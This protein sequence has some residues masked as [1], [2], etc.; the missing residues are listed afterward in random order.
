MIE[1]E[2]FPDFFAAIY[3]FAPFPWQIRLLQQVADSGR[4]PKL[5]DLPTGSG[6][7]ACIDIAVFHLAWRLSH[8]QAS[9]AARR[10]A[11]VVDRRIVVDQAADRARGLATALKT[12]PDPILARV[13]GCLRQGNAHNDPLRVITLRGGTLRERAV[14]RSLVEPTIILSTVD[15]LG[16]RMLFRGYGVSKRAAPMHAGMLA[17]DTLVLLDEAHIALPLLQTL[18]GIQRE[19]QRMQ[20][21]QN[22]PS[23]TGPQGFALAELTA[24]PGRWP[25]FS[26][27][28]DDHAHPLLAQRLN[29]SKP[30]TLH[31][32]EDRKA[33]VKALVEAVEETLKAPPT[34]NETPR[35]A[36]VVNRV[37]SAREIFE[38][39]AKKL[40]KSATVIL[41]TGRSRP[42]DRDS[43]LNE[44]KDALLASMKPRPGDKAIVVV[45]TQTIEVGADFDFH[46]MLSEA[47]SYPALRQRL[48]RLN[49]LGVR[50]QARAAIYLVEKQADSDPIYGPSLLRT[51]RFLK[52]PQHIQPLDLGILAAP[53]TTIDLAPPAALTPYLTASL[54][55]LLVQTNPQPALDPDVNALLHGF[56]EREA[57][58]QMVWRAGLPSEPKADQLDAL[59]ILTHLPPTSP[60][61]LALSRAQF[62]NW[63]GRLD[64]I[65]QPPGLEDEA[66]LESIG[67][68]PD[69]KADAR[70]LVWIAKDDGWE[71]IAA[72]RVRPGSTVVVPAAWGG[73]DAFGFSP[74]Q[75]DAVSDLGQAAR[76][77][78]GLRET[79]VLT[80]PRLQAFASGDVDPAS[81]T[82][83]SALCARVADGELPLSSARVELAEMLQRL[84]LAP[85]FASQSL[86]ETGRLLPINREDEIL[87]FVLISK[88]KGIQDFTEDGQSLQR[89]VDVE[90]HAHC[91][92]VGQFAELAAKTLGLSAEL[93]ND[94]RLAGRLHDLGKADPRF[95]RLLGG[96]GTRLLAKSG[97]RRGS[98]LNETS[99]RH[100]AYS[101]AAA[102]THPAL[103]AQARDRSLVLH[104]VGSHHGYGRAL[105]PDPADRGTAFATDV[106]G[107]PVHYS[108]CASLGTLAAAWPEQFFALN[109]R[110]GPWGLAFLET[111]LRLAD[112]QRSA[113][114]VEQGT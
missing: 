91:R 100:E 57:D 19:Q 6:K 108:G 89:T 4:W 28:Q 59:A 30:T 76:Q 8:G 49:R 93:V 33:L 53:A 102:L 15:Q 85:L 12:N 110:Y 21:N 66:D 65:K 71:P 94:L 46:V 23:P 37:G 82:A 35:I 78:L 41:L 44:H 105:Q 111:L 32:V 3:G 54:L 87:G 29:A 38:L 114:E 68:A 107:T 10:I 39:L 26:L 106:D 17:F 42:L 86:L 55:D 51:W 56:N 79:A 63:I 69:Q 83:W 61:T 58:I 64:A 36:V 60:E 18:D 74:A 101:V 84:A 31:E 2:D 50:T 47:A 88:A 67:R 52:D 98:P 77:R 9:G 20:A 25:E 113:W 5:I 96:D 73:C 99:E 14:V 103:L 62:L 75:P 48:G 27:D 97:E 109:R 92:G 112:H 11:F 40:K 95:Q 81:R 90:L 70:R 80:W 104:L 43:L 72:K 45:A 24:T 13:A 34:A 16:S 1:L 22:A 7:T